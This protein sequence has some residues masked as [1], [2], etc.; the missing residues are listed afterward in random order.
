MKLFTTTIL[1]GLFL[2]LQAQEESNSLSLKSTL[3]LSYS[4]DTSDSLNQ[5]I[6]KRLDQ[7]L[8]SKD[9]SLIQNQTWLKSD[10]DTFKYPFLDLYKIEYAGSKANVFNADLLQIIKLDQPDSYLLKIAFV[11]QDSKQLSGLKSMYNLLASIIDHKIYFSRS[12]NHTIADWQKIDQFPITYY[13]SPNKEVNEHEIKHQLEDIKT[14]NKYFETDSITLTYYSCIN[15]VELFQVKGFDYTPGMYFDKK[16]G[17]V[18][19]GNHVFSGNNSEYYTHEITHIYVNTLFPKA[20]SLLNEGI[21]TF[22]GGSGGLDYNWHKTN[23]INY[24]QTQK[25]FDFLNYTQAYDKIYVDD[26]TSIPYMTG[27]LIYEY[28]IDSYDK[29]TFFSLL[30]SPNDLWET[31]QKVELNKNNFT[32]KLMPYLQK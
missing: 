8:L 22:F 18:E 20:N 23:L 30:K 25:D 15:P 7:F 3:R 28:V 14:L 29:H 2:S 4:V 12:L 9:S 16:G 11:G 32:K 24:I 19:Y 26:E 21:A 31:L 1:F 10:F 17:I 6:I 27:A 13:I 5:E